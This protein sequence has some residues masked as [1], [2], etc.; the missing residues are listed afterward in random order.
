MPVWMYC[1]YVDVLRQKLVRYAVFVNDIVVHAGAGACRTK[2]ET[3]ESEIGYRLAV[4][5]M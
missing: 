2:E 3:E 1:T 5:L 4:F